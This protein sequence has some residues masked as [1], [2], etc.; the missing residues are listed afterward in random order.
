HDL[1]RTH[2]KLIRQCLAAYRGAEIVHTGDGVEASFTSASSAVECA[3]AIQKAFA[4]H[5]REQ[6]GEPIQLRIGINAG[7]P[8]PTEGRLFGPAAPSAFRISA[9]AQPGQILV[10]EVV[11]QLVASRGF[12]LV[13][14]GR[15][16]LKGLGR[17]RLYAVTWQSD[18]A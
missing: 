14:R 1:I 13:N 2:N 6:G 18:D 4:R 12:P 3:V 5:N 8:I 9:R 11:Q 7:E 17:V 10:S 15:V 16:N